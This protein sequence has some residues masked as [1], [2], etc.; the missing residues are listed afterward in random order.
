MPSSILAGSATLTPRSG[1]AP[2]PPANAPI[3]SG[4][5]APRW[6]PTT[7]TRALV[8]NAGQFP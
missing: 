1:A 6:F 8:S 7:A 4:N 5:T 3:T 2:R